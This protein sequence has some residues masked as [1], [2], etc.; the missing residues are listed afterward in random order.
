MVALGVVWCVVAGSTIPGDNLGAL[1]LMKI[2]ENTY[3]DQILSLFFKFCVIFSMFETF[4]PL[5]MTLAV[6]VCL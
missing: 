6:F 2:K 1:F 3:F 4:W 5:M